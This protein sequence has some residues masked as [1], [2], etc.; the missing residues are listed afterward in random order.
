LLTTLAV[1]GLFLLAA[2]LAPSLSGLI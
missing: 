2:A 1:D